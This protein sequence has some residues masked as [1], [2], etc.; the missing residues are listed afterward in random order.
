MLGKYL[1]PHFLELTN[2]S[3]VIGY[4]ERQEQLKK[5]IHLVK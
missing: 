5:V 3:R 1:K 4:G 2:I